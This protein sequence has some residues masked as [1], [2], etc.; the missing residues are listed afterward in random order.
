MTGRK[1]ELFKALSDETRL[2]L[3]NLFLV[4]KEPLCVCE[5]TDALNVPQYQISKHL[6]LLKYMGLIKHEKHGKWAYY[7][8][9]EGNPVNDQLFKFLRDFLIDPPFQSDWQ[10]LQTRLCLRQNGKCVIGAIAAEEWDGLLQGKKLI[11]EANCS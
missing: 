3:L 6:S 4:S 10:Y 9:N 2:R 8:L 7:S 5:L 11:R 1:S